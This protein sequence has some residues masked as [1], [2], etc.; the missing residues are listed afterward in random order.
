MAD[1]ARELRR[2]ATPWLALPPDHRHAP[3]LPRPRHC[4][5]PTQA[6]RLPAFART[7]HQVLAASPADACVEAVAGA[8][9]DLASAPG[10]SREPASEPQEF[11]SLTRATGLTPTN[12][13]RLSLSD[14]TSYNF[15]DLVTARERKRVSTPSAGGNLLVA[16]LVHR[17]TVGPAS[18]R[19]HRAEAPAFALRRVS[20]TARDWSDAGPRI[21]PATDL[22]A[23]IVS[24]LLF[25]RS[26]SLAGDRRVARLSRNSS[27]ASGGL[28]PAC[29]R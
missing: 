6:A 19:D 26:A 27:A 20:T 10:E 22:M 8:W 29:W 2:A 4:R 14:T 1:R 17:A 15:V 24:A 12:C 23:A 5:S 21:H 7:S 25:A 18:R 11:R 3:R 16:S 13:R 9:P 28:C